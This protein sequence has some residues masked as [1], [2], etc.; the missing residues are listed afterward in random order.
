[1]FISSL[2]NEYL[3]M[4]GKIWKWAFKVWRIVNSFRTLLHFFGPS[5]IFRISLDGLRSLG[6]RPNTQ[7]GTHISEGRF[8]NP[9]LLHEQDEVESTTNTWAGRGWRR[10]GSG[11]GRTASTPTPGI[12]PGRTGI[13]LLE[14]KFKKNVIIFFQS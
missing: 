12:S 5:P 14:I 1:M 13:R 7:K 4:N 6:Q 2:V 3:T 8:E 10:R 9:Q 11:T